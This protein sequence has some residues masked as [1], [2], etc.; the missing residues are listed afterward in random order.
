VLQT[1]A[2]RLQRQKE[3]LRVAVQR[4]REAV[5]NGLEDEAVGA[6]RQMRAMLLDR[7]NGEQRHGAIPKGREVRCLQIRPA[8]DAEAHVPPPPECIGAG[9]GNL[10]H[11]RIAGSHPLPGHNGRA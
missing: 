4:G 3:N 1:V 7:G 10:V 2:D 8:P 5:E 6:E 11:L 9:D